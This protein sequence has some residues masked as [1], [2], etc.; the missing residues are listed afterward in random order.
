MPETLNH[1]KDLAFLKDRIATNKAKGESTEA[2]EACLSLGET[3][4]KRMKPAVSH[5]EKTIPAG[6]L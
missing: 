6:D 2:I 4:A 3:M 5:I 1:L